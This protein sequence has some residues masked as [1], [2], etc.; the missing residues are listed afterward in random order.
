M[1][2]DTDVFVML[3]HFYN[4]KCKGTN[5]TLFMS[6]PIKDRAVVDIRATAE[7][8]NDIA[9]EFLAIHGISGAD[10]AASLHGI[11]KAT[12]LKVAKKGNCSLS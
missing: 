7:T 5:V 1:C 6:S 3:V 4:S 11:G 8:H 9:D 2:H 12:V 10:T